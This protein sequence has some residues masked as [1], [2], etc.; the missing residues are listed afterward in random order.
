LAGE[1][2]SRWRQRTQPDDPFEPTA[3]RALLQRWAD[4]QTHPHERISGLLA[5]LHAASSLEIRTLILDDIDHQLTSF[6]E[7]KS[8]RASEQGTYNARGSN[9]NNGVR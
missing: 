3:Q 9:M 8:C 1:R 4:A 7:P 6:G 2:R 5:L